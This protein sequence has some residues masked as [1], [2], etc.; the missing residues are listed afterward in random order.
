MTGTFYLELF[1]FLV[2]HALDHVDGWVDV[3]DEEDEGEPCLEGNQV[4][5]VYEWWVWHPL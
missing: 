2:H 5:V 1:F 3:G 4:F